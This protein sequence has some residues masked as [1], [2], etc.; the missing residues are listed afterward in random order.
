MCYRRTAV[1]HFRHE[2]DPR[3]NLHLFVCDIQADLFPQENATSPPDSYVCLVSS[4]EEI[5]SKKTNTVKQVYNAMKKFL[6]VAESNKVDIDSDASSKG[7]PRTGVIKSNYNPDWTN[8]E[9]HCIMK[10][11]RDDG[12]P[13]KLEGAILHIFVFKYSARQ[14]DEVI[15]SYPVNLESI[16]RSCSIL[17]S[18]T[19]TRSKS[20]RQSMRSSMR[21]S[22]STMHLLPRQGGEAGFHDS[23]NNMVSVEINGPLLK[24]GMQTGV[25]RCTVDAWLV[26]DSLESAADAAAAAM[27]TDPSQNGASSAA[28]GSESSQAM[29][30]SRHRRIR[31]GEKR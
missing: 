25:L 7:W 1:F 3:D 13:I 27:A 10:T 6:R 2:N 5:L 22:L 19:H 18:G 14:T 8:R 9:I 17:G 24:N 31:G 23:H 11:Y 30:S 15:G 26:E 16:F 28:D 29:F 21:K 4:P 12:F 20:W